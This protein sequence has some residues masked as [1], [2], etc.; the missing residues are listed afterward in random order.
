M[1]KSREE[2]WRDEYKSIFKWERLSSISGISHL[3]AYLEARKKAQVE[4][5]ELKN[6]LEKLQNFTGVYVDTD[7]FSE[8]EQENKKLKKQLEKANVVINHVCHSTQDSQSLAWEYLEANKVTKEL[9]K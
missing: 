8:F 1:S 3:D 6:K 9:E 4:I 7:S 2:T 5:D